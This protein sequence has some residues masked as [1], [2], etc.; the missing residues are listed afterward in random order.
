MVFTRS[1]LILVLYNT[2]ASSLPSMK[3][4]ITTYL[5][6]QIFICRIFFGDNRVFCRLLGLLA[7]LP[8]DFRAVRPLPPAEED[9]RHL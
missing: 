5:L 9:R 4:M 8:A 2:R 3:K 6:F 7:T 1:F